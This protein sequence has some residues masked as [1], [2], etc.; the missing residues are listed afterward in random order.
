MLQVS[1]KDYVL[2]D[3][4]GNLTYPLTE[5]YYEPGFN[6]MSPLELEF[7]KSDQISFYFKKRDN[8]TGETFSNI[9]KAT[10]TVSVTD[11]TN[12]QIVPNVISNDT[13]TRLS[14][15]ITNGLTMNSPTIRVRVIDINIKDS[16]DDDFLTFRV[17]VD[18]DSKSFYYIPVAASDI[19]DR[20]VSSIPG[21]D[22]YMSV[23]AN[24][25]NYLVF[26]P[27]VSIRETTSNKSDFSYPLNTIFY[28]R[29]DSYNNEDYSYSISSYSN[30][31]MRDVVSVMNVPSYHKVGVLIV[32]NRLYKDII[33]NSI[34]PYIDIAVSG[35]L[36]GISDT[37]RVNFTV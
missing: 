27:Y 10:M 19:G 22:I 31:F 29:Q 9:T 7:P 30:S 17:L 16:T 5:V 1:R 2:V 26:S 25:D 20:S 37:F 24:S 4:D 11:P 18:D 32:D 13:A 14:F 8:S 36:S 15:T 33:E 23:G 6:I 3:S 35:N 34:N 28:K 21:R 12:G